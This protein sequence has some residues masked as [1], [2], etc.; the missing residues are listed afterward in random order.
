MTAQHQSLR[1]GIFERFW[2]LEIL[3]LVAG[4][5][6]LVGIVTILHKYDGLAVADW[7]LAITINSL[8]SIF[9]VVLKGAMLLAVAQGVFSQRHRAGLL[10]T[11]NFC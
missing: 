10:L 3:G 4:I 2:I 6:S 9:I 1:D 5:A 7:P 8:I 11:E